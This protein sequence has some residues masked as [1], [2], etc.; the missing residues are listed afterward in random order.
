MEKE[1]YQMHGQVSQ[2]SCYWTTGHL[3]DTHGPGRD[4]RGNKEPPD[5]TLCGRRFGSMCPMR[6][7]AKKNKNGL[8][9]NQRSTTPKDCVVFTSLIL[10][11]NSRTSWKNARRKLEIPMPAAMPCKTPVN[12]SGET[13]RGIGKSKTKYA[14]IVEADESTRI[15]LEGVP[16]W[17]HEDHI[18]AITKSLQFCTQM[19]SNVPSRRMKRPQFMSK[20][21]ICSWQW[22]SSRIRQQFYR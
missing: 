20:N 3:T 14:C 5:Q 11:R 21:W 22:K 7:N 13:Y 16:C 9:R 17:Y 4:W 19:C 18:A 6:R 8:S 15:R 12:S 10:V 2:D 1:N